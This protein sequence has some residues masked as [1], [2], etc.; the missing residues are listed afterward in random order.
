MRVASP[1]A[2]TYEDLMAWEDSA[3]QAKFSGAIQYFKAANK[4]G[5]LHFEGEMPREKLI[6]SRSLYMT[7]R[8]L[9]S[10]VMAQPQLIG[11]SI[12]ASRLRLRILGPEFAG[13][14]EAFTEGT[15]DASFPGH[16]PTSSRAREI[17]ASRAARDHRELAQKLGLGLEQF[18][19][20]LLDK[21]KEAITSTIRPAGSQEVAPMQIPVAA[22]PH[23]MSFGCS[24]VL[25]TSKEYEC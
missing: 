4:Y 19:Q 1:D 14:V 13:Q 24:P 17:W 8:E 25:V 18:Q 20:Y 3:L 6:T 7:R 11:S 5:L 15:F 16:A 21:A 12:D 9:L 22:C 23:L 10:A 2:S